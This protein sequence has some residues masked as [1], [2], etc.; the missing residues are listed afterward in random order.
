MIEQIIEAIKKSDIALIGHI[1]VDDTGPEEDY[2]YAEFYYQIDDRID[3]MDKDVEDSI[4]SILGEDYGVN[5][6]RLDEYANGYAYYCV[7][8]DKILE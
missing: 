8:I 5:V 4:L 2:F 6:N 1:R 7:T 3:R